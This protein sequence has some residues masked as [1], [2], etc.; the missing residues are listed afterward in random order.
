MSDMSSVVSSRELARDTRAIVDRLDAG[1]TIALQ[2][3]G[4][5]VGHLIPSEHNAGVDVPPPNNPRGLRDWR[6]PVGPISTRGSEALAALRED[7]R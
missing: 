3:R 5:I 1:E 6:P 2:R 7:E 4:K